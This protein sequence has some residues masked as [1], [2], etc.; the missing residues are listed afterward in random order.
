MQEFFSP[1]VVLSAYDHS[2]VEEM[3]SDG[4]K[5]LKKMVYKER[6]NAL[7]VQMGTLDDVQEE[8]LVSIQKEYGMLTRKLKELEG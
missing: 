3:F 6:L 7:S 2:K 8:A 4:L 1:E 5:E